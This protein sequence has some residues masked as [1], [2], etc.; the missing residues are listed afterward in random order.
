MA[1]VVALIYSPGLSN[2]EKRRY[3]YWSKELPDVSH[4]V[5]G[6]TM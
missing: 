3:L 5:L 4:T 1:L 6:Y 2:D